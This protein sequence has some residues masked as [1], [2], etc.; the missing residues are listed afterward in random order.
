MVILA[1]GPGAAPA[2]GASV[3]DDPAGTGNSVGAK[4][5]ILIPENLQ[6]YRSILC[7]SVT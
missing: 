6:R 5:N 7:G 3:G 1:A 4:E 2:A